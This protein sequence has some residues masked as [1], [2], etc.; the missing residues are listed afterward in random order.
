MTSRILIFVIGII[1]IIFGV[2]YLYHS[3]VIPS[4]TPDEAGRLIG[5]D[6]FDYIID[7]RTPEEWNEGH[8]PKAVLIP[9]ADFTTELPQKIQNKNAEILFVCR[10]GIRSSAA[11][12]MAHDLGFQ[13]VAYVKGYHYGLRHIAAL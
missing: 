8:H 13:N 3:N 5:E 10:K 6:K 4:Y 2:I 7:V 9:L 11:A 1:V 12:S